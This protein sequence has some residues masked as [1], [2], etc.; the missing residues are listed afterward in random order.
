MSLPKLLCLHGEGSSAAILRVQLRLL[1][2]HLAPRFDFVFV[3][4]PHPCPAGVDIADFFE[5][6]YRSWMAPGDADNARTWAFLDAIVAER[7]PFVGL[8]AFSQGCRVATGLL[9]RQ[10][11][12]E[13]TAEGGFRA[14]L[15]IGG[16]T[17]PLPLLAGQG[18]AEAGLVAARE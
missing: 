18:E 13:E 16:T 10:A 15:L 17:P 7:G 8:V 6:P 11:L 3:D 1:L 4:A 5:G 14:A 9:Q 2:H 12:R